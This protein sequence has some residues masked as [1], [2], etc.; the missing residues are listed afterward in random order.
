MSRQ[1][2]REAGKTVGGVEEKKTEFDLD[3]P[4]AFEK[5]AW[6]FQ[7]RKRKERRGMESASWDK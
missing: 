5:K 7:R 2:E 1:T 6:A 4:P 3:G